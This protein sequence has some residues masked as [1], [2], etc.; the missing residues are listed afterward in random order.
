MQC[1]RCSGYTELD[2]APSCPHRASPSPGV[3]SELSWPTGDDGQPVS[4]ERAI[5]RAEALDRAAT[6]WVE[7]TSTDDEEL[8]AEIIRI[9]DRYHPLGAIQRYCQYYGVGAVYG[10]GSGAL[11]AITHEGAV[12]AGAESARDVA[13]ERPAPRP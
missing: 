1:W 9:E 4:L 2:H 8:D 11:G 10:D 7:F 3:V 13:I 6:Y 12:V 5:E